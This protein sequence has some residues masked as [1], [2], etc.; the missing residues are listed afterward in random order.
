VV[1]CKSVGGELHCL[2]F[3]NPLRFAGTGGDRVR[4]QAS[5]EFYLFQHP[6]HSTQ[7]FQAPSNTPSAPTFLVYLSRVGRNFLSTLT[8]KLTGRVQF[9]QN[10][11]Q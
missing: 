5:N 7:P 1:V 9:F 6:L 3:T 8:D 11:A 10:R 4:Q 2:L